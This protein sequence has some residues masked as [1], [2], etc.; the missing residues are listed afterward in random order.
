M[1]KV[2]NVHV[3]FDKLQVLKGINL[4]ISK[5][6]IVSII[7]SSGAGKTTLLQVVG[8]LEEPDSGTIEINDTDI[9]ILKSNQLANRLQNR[10]FSSW[11]KTQLLER[12]K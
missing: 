6:E 9:S 7:G 8:T 5:G 10:G 1:I 3:S 12:F 11:L 2:S 4:D